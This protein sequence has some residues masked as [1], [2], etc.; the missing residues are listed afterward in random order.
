MSSSARATSKPARNNTKTPHAFMISSLLHSAGHTSLRRFYQLTDAA[1][2]AFCVAVTRQRVAAAGRF[3]QN[4]RPKDA[5]LDVDGRDLGDADAD[6]V[7][8]EPRPF[9]ADD[10]LVRHF[11]DGGKQEIPAR[12]TAR[13]KCFRSHDRIIGHSAGRA[14]DFSSG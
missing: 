13:L 10:R 14:T 4:V 5:G 11:D 2:I 8:A 3:N 7:L 12:P 6:F 1:G 9:A